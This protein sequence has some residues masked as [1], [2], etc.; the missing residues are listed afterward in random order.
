MESRHRE[1]GFTL[2]ELMIVVAIIG[3]LAGLAIYGVSRY[4]KHAKTAEATRMLSRIESGADAHY[5]V[6]SNETDPDLYVH[7]FCPNAGP[8]P[9]VFPVAQKILPAPAEFSAPGWKCLRFSANAP[10][11]YQYDY[12]TNGLTA[13]NANFTATA[14][15][16]LDG[17][18]ARSLFR[19]VAKGGLYGDTV[20][21][22][23]TILN[24]DN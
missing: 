13:V 20:R 10:L 16:D 17:D 5:Q 14:Q 6:E 7:E 12:K 24:E 9:T 1:R 21:V 8:T 3:V 15:G 4:L 19:I 2:V 18:G 23:F 22:E 11:F